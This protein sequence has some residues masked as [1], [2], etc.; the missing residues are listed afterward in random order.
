MTQAEIK[1][2]NAALNEVLKVLEDHPDLD[3]ELL[4]GTQLGER[5]DR[6][7]EILTQAEIDTRWPHDKA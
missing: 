4:Q 5:L 6:A 7:T 3:V 1:A 2:A